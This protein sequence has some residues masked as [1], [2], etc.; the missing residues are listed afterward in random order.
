[1]GAP[2]PSAIETEMRPTTSEILAPCSTRLATS[3]PNWSLPRRYPDPG[4]W[5]AVR[6][7]VLIGSLGLSQG[8]PMASSARTPRITRPATAPRWRISRRGPSANADPRVDEGVRDVDE[9]VDHHVRRRH[10]QHGALHERKVLGEDSADDQPPQ[11]RAAEHGLDDD[12]AGQEIPE[13]QAED[14]DDRAQRVL[15]RVADDHAP[16]RHALR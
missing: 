3:R 14:R 12:G 6:G 11:S 10:E 1:M 16:P 15:Q 2:R 4:A 9:D 8:A 13:L 7:A 5:S